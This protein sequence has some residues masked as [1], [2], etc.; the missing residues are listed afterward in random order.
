MDLEFK[1]ILKNENIMQVMQDFKTRFVFELPVD[2]LIAVISAIYRE[3][4]VDRNLFAYVPAEIEQMIGEL[5][6]LFFFDK[7][8]PDYFAYFA[9]NIPIQVA[10][11]KGIEIMNAAT[12]NFVRF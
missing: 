7:E 2:R 10:M 5:Y 1:D 6:L 4:L 11:S 3:E 12:Q 9:K 8:E